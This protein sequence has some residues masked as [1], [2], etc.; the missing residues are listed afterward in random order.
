MKP[1]PVPIQVPHPKGISLSNYAEF[2]YSAFYASLNLHVANFEDL[3]HGDK[4]AWEAAA[5]EALKLA[6]KVIVTPLPIH[7]V[8]MTSGNVTDPVQKQAREQSE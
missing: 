7:Y 3:G 5:R 1:I 2:I 6:P 4:E 8:G